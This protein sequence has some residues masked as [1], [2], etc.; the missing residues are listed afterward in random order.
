VERRVAPA[1]VLGIDAGIRIAPRFG[2]GIQ[3]SIGVPL[4]TGDCVAASQGCS[5]QP[6]DYVGASGVLTYS[7]GRRAPTLSA[8]AGWFRF[9]KTDATPSQGLFGLLGAVELPVRSGRV[10]A[11][12]IGV[13]ATYLP[14]SSGEEISLWGLYIR[15]R[16]AP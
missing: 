7:F 4:G 2:L 10:T 3:G 5:G 9:D 1:P 12:S 8:G 11:L 6:N 14:N 13:R 15:L 16:A